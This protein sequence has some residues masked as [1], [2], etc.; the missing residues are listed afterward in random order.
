LI[1]EPDRLR[2]AGVIAASTPHN[3]R[4]TAKQ[5]GQVSRWVEHFY[6]TMRSNGD[7]ALSQEFSITD[8]E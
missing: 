8:K 3:H 5:N 2:A 7:E 4:Q 6:G 1:S